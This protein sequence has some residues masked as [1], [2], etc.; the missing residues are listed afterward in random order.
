MSWLVI[1][2]LTALPKAGDFLKFIINT[3]CLLFR[4]K[5]FV[6]NIKTSTSPLGGEAQGV[7]LEYMMTS[8]D[9]S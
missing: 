8:F 1:V 3:C 4:V 2:N 5:I 9:N 6:N 7:G